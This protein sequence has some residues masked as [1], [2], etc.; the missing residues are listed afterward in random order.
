M[1]MN[2]N[3]LVGPGID[4]VKIVGSARHHQDPSG[5]AGLAETRTE[6]GGNVAL[7]TFRRGIDVLV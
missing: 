6:V 3:R 1:R 2:L 5:L 7:F 4:I